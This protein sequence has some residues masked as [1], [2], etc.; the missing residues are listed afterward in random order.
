MDKS[1]ENLMSRGKDTTKWKKPQNT[2]PSDAKVPH[3]VPAVMP[4]P[5]W[6]GAIAS[7]TNMKKATFTKL[8]LIP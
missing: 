4:S 3:V 8:V 6:E 2:K 7:H 1:E 5:A